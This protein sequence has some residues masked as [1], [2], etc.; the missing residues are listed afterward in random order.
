MGGGGELL[1]L[2]YPTYNPER[3]CYKIL[4]YILFATAPFTLAK[5]E[6]ET[7]KVQRDRVKETGEEKGGSVRRQ[8]RNGETRI[9][10]CEQ[11]NDS[12]SNWAE[13]RCGELFL[14]LAL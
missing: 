13:M 9:H 1:P 8:M 6:T 2:R 14:I 11:P 5:Y 10:D 12:Y 4:N 7:V 3:R